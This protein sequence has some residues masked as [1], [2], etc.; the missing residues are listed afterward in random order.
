MT[1]D[2]ALHRVSRAKRACC[3]ACPHF[4]SSS[5]S[6]S[7]KHVPAYLGMHAPAR[8][9]G[10]AA[11][12]KEGSTKARTRVWKLVSGALWAGQPRATGV[13]G[14]LIW[15][16]RKAIGSSDQEKTIGQWEGD[17]MCLLIRRGELVP[18]MPYCTLSSRYVPMYRAYS[19]VQG[20]S[21]RDRPVKVVKPTHIHT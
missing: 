17:C 11:Q 4:G 21:V 18:F 10:Y 12:E 15:T 2:G 8:G 13:E 1:S 19:T 6:S 20:S 9:G 16:E 7:N 14:T 3:A 5:I